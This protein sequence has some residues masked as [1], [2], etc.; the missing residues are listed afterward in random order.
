[1]GR[2]PGS[3]RRLAALLALAGATGLAAACDDGNISI[4]ENTMSLGGEAE[5]ASTWTPTA[6]EPITLELIA[7]RTV[8]RGAEVPIRVNVHNGSDRPIGVGFGLRRGFNVLVTREKGRADSSAV[9]SLPIF[10]GTARDPTV[11][12]PLL[13]G[14]DTAFS[15][16]WP[17]VDDA[18]RM[19]PPGAYRIRATVSA[20]LVSTRQLWTDWTPVTV[21]ER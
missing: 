21:V 10:G 19:V 13:P 6:R 3:P 4:D 5:Q 2:L 20:A 17:G 12:D 1:V 9:W 18:G 15:V 16:V 14:R 11:T 8:A 7:P